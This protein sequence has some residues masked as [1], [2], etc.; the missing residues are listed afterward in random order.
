VVVAGSIASDS[1]G[2]SDLPP[3]PTAGG[4]AAPLAYPG[5]TWESREP[6]SLGLSRTKLDALA[7][8]VGGCGCVVRH[9]YMAYTWGDTAGS[10]D[11]ASA[12]KPVIST[13]LLLAIQEGRL[14]SVD[15]KVAE[16]EPRLKIQSAGK[17]ARITWRH[18]ASQT[19]GYGLVEPPGAAYA[20][21]DFALALYYD[22]LTRKVF[23]DDG[24]HV[25]KTRLAETLQFQ[26]RYTFNAFNRD[27]RQGRLAVSVRDLARFGLL[28]LRGGR[29]Q[30]RVIIRPDF[31]RMALGSPIPAELPR[32]SGTEAPMLPGQRSLGGGK[33]IAAVG[34]GYYSF[35]WWLN[36]K[37]RQGRRLFRFAPPDTFVAAGHG[38]QRM[39]WIVPS[40]DLI[41]CWND[42]EIDDH[43]KSPGD[44]STRCNQAALLIH[45]SVL[46]ET[47]AAVR[48]RPH[49]RVSVVA[50]RWHMNGAVT[51]PGAAAEG[52]LMNVRMANAVFEDPERSAFDPE[53]NTDE[54]I[55]RISD[56]TSHGIR[57]FTIG[58]Q[59]GFPGYEGA[60]NSAFGADGS[61]RAGTMSR[62]RRVLD[63]C[64]RSG[65]VVILGC[66]YQRQDQVLSSEPA[67]RAGVT[68]VAEWVAGQGFDNVILEIANE[69]G[70]QG[71][72]HEVLRNAARHADL[73]RLAKR[74]APA[75]LVS[76]SGSGDG[77]LDDDVARAC[78]VLLVHFNG[79]PLRAIPARVASLRKYGKPIVCN[80]DA[81]V[82]RE[83]AD[84]ARRC[85]SAGASWGL[86]VE[87]V[88]QRFPFAF[89]GACDDPIVYQTLKELTSH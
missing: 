37:D 44:P 9:G 83:G 52:L 88:N 61:L 46:E 19:S 43:D 65:A 69:Y 27:D 80:E 89:R 17:D 16:F 63:A 30:D 50:G 53:S 15:D 28:Y 82:G 71:F 39:L 26:D 49:T 58:L 33:N 56:Y 31:V 5:A 57:A 6:R 85:V 24:T 8:L 59:G 51:Y 74:A 20:Y 2:A 87:S 18:L 25:L 45:Q 84:A 4:A 77:T 42:S 11:I 79:T 73:I 86:M 72:N 22:T 14:R 35:N 62:V 38:G 55:T 70:H 75:L 81:K 23:R 48:T 3:A 1:G 68:R 40:L 10:R 29:W 54:F 66:F 76:T 32:T 12:V 34:Q 41:V 13:L 60:R 78:D 67:V 7:K 47:Y 64:D 36:G 21:N